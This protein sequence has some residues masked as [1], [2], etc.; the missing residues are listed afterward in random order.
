MTAVV[1]AHGFATRQIHAGVAPDPSHGSAV[2]PIHLT[3]GFAFDDF[4]AARDRFGDDPDGYVYSRYGNPTVA[5]LERKVADLESGASAIAVGS[6]QAAVSVALLGLLR[7]GDRVLSSTEVYEGSRGLLAEDFARFGI[8]VD[9]VTEP[10]DPEAWRRA[11]RP[12]TRVLFGETVSNPRNEVLDIPAIAAVAH[13]AGLP[14]VVDSTLT[15]PYLLRPL[16]LGA[17]VVVHSA[18]K[19]LSGHGAALGGVLVHAATLADRVAE[20]RALA[21]RLGPSLSPV[22]AFLLQQGIE[23]LSL[24]MDR[25]TSTARTIAEWLAAR[26]EVS[27]VDSAALPSH[28][29]HELARR[30]LPRGTGSVFSFTL[31]GGEPAARAVLDAVRLFTR[32]SHLG[33]TRSLILHPATTSHARRTPDELLAAGIAP[34][35]LRLSVGLED[36]ADLL[37][38]LERAFAALPV[39]RRE[40]ARHPHLAHVRQL[41]HAALALT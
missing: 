32:M 5:A 6:G 30:L 22:N 4:D 24:R 31:A 23:T 16:E 37:A 21:S 34:G 25:H 12:E 33:D 27:G 35:T 9:F 3:A 11:I 41:T 19:F 8:G 15:T 2:T 28:P 38:D 29:R 7:A 20:T 1:P 14:L 26:S 13:A 18:S 39:E 36:P 40:P 10:H 17:D